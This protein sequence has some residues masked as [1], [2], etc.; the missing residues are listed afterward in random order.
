MAHGSG[1]N[2]FILLITLI[3]L[4]NGRKRPAVS[5][6][7]KGFYKIAQ[8]GTVLRRF[9]G[10]QAGSS[11]MKRAPCGWLSAIEIRPLC[12]SMM[13]WAM[14]SPRPVPELFLEK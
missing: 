12:S 1:S 10:P 4:K 14:A 7:G 5:F 3:L 11:M 13:L 9:S 2:L 6:P 8:Q